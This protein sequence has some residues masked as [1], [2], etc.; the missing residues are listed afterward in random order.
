MRDRTPQQTAFAQS[1]KAQ[2]LAAQQLFVQ[3]GEPALAL[4]V[5]ALIAKAGLTIDLYVN[6]E[7]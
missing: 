3:A 2:L 6:Q 7:P 4:A 5:G 1:A